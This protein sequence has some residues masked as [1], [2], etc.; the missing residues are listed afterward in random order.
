[1]GSLPEHVCVAGEGFDGVIDSVV[2][3]LSDWFIFCAIFLVL[4]S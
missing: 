4:Y 2:G 1:M 3:P